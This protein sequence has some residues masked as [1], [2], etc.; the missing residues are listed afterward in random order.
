MAPRYRR[1]CMPACGTRHG[2]M[3]GNVREQCRNEYEIPSSACGFEALW[4]R[5]RQAD[6]SLAMIARPGW[7]ALAKKATRMVAVQ[8]VPGA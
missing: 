8:W 7:A 1:Q 6:A 3:H 4:S 5:R 2:V